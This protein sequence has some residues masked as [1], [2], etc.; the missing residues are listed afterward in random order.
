M[1]LALIVGLGIALSP[2]RCLGQRVVEVYE[3]V[4]G[5]LRIGP[6]PERQIAMTERG[7][8]LILPEGAPS[9]VEGVA[10][11]IDPRRFASSRPPFEPGSFDAEAVARGLA[12]LHISTGNPLDFLFQEEEVEDLADR[13]GA[14]LMDAGLE[15]EPVFLGGLSL[16]GTRALRLAAYLISN[17]ERPQLGLAAVAVVDAP[18]D[19]VRLWG[20]ERRA[21]SL[22]FHDAAADEG[23]W[24]IYLLETHLGG[25]PEIALPRYVEFSPFLHGAPDGGNAVHLR[26]LPIRAY[27]EPDVDW[28]IENR[29]KSYYDMNSIDLAALINQL[30]VLGNERAEL[31]SSHQQ[32]AGYAEGATPHTWSIVDNRDLVAWFLSQVP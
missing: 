17:P 19:M 8:S 12:V 30:R 13:I 5:Y 31:V 14:V 6:E 11:F 16:G 18:L 32:R 4:S 27:H 29:R 24:V 7:Y 21:A 23:R 3:D 15:H 20:T 10:V 28:W 22:G 1:R 9:T 26:D 2:I 25:G